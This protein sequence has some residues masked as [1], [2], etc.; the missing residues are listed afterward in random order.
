MREPDWPTARRLAAAAHPLAAER[1]PLAQADGRVLAGA[2]VAL[3]DLPAF[4][5]SS[6]DGWAV[7]GDGP[8]RLVGEVLA[9]HAPD[10]RLEPGQCC[11]IATGAAVPDGATAVVRREHGEAVGDTVRADR[12]PGADI[13]PAGEECRRGDVLARAGSVVGPALIG[14]FAAAGLDEVQVRPAP[15]VAVV[16]FG[17]ELVG[18]GVAGIGQV[19]DSLGPQLPGWLTRMGASVV[20]VTR[21]ADTLAEHVDRIREA[22]TGADVVITTGGTAAGPVDHLHA[23]VAQLD[24]RFLIDSVAVRPGHP[25]AMADLGNAWLVALPGNPQSAIVAL[26]SLG[27]PLIDSL[28]GRPAAELP[29]VVLTQDT[30]A[31]ATEHRL[32][33]ASLADG[34]ATP[35]QH[36]G[37]A[38][39]RGL[40]AADGFAVMPPGGA[41]AGDTVQWLALP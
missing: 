27:S 31:P 30:K 12:E 3:T 29:G 33:A 20:S 4:D 34:E 21:A 13:R 14:L 32:V 2:V 35:V 19:R 6:M 15:R 28:L 11:V 23:A 39:L 16:L 5:T 40:A 8:W 9:G 24:G 38:M 41:A 17:D 37:S 1:V 10:V 25:M 36:L 7:S 18:Q 22:A 26:I